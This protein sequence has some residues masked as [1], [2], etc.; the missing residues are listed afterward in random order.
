MATDC[1]LGS[2]PIRIDY[3]TFLFNC[4]PARGLAVGFLFSRIQLYVLLSPCACV[5][6]FSYHDLYV[7]EDGALIS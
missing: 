7:L 3:F 6:S 2:Q 5:I 1:M 4:T